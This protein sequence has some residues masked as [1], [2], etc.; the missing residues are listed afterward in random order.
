MAP[1]MQV[2][3]FLATALL[4]MSPLASAGG[5]QGGRERRVP[6]AAS[7]PNTFF[8]KEG[9]QSKPKGGG[10]M[11]NPGTAFWAKSSERVFLEYTF[12]VVVVLYSIWAVRSEKQEK[13]RKLK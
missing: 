8:G 4:A 5:I 7:G 9:D 13:R 10:G 1:A 2:P 12:M 11:G 6:G 3:I